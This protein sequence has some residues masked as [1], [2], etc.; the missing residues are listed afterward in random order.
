FGVFLDELTSL[1]SAAVA[2]QPAALAGLPIQYADFA[3]WQR[4][5]LQGAALEEQLAY[6]TG[7]LAGAPTTLNLPADRPRPAVQTFQGAAQHF[8]LSAGLSAALRALSKREDATL[9]MTMLAAFQVLLMRYSGQTDLV[10]GTPI[11]GRTR[12]ELEGLI[13]LF[14]NTLALRT[15][16]A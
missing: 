2:G 9:Y 3:A 14:I 11:A 13:G 10:I 7:R 8:K 1:Y 15:S 5:W 6:W 4:E 16:L 12:T